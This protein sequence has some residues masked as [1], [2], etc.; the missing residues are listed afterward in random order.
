[1]SYWT[2]NQHINPLFDPDAPVG[3]IN[4][5]GDYADPAEH[6]GM[7]LNR[8]EQAHQDQL[9]INR[10]QNKTN[11]EFR[12]DLDE[13]KHIRRG[14]R[15]EYLDAQEYGRE[16][17]KKAFALYEKVDSKVDAHYEEFK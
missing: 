5:A 4:S 15:K 7:R 9:E 10:E 2:P 1:M 6:C 13:S 17:Q 16:K 14:D 8:L 12:V 11:S 3:F